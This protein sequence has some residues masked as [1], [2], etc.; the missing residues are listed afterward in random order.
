MVAVTTWKCVDKGDGNDDGDEVAWAIL[1]P[2][3]GRDVMHWGA[4]VKA[5]ATESAAL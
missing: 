2:Y 3:H 4:M 5:I 1:G